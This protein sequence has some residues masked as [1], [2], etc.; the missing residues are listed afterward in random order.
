QLC[1]ELRHRDW[2]GQDFRNTYALLGEKDIGTVI[3]DTAGRRDVLHMRLTAPFVFIRWVGNGGHPKDFARLEDWGHRLKTW[4]DKGMR[5][6]YFIIH[7]PD[8]GYAPDLVLRAVETFNA[9]CGTSLKPPKLLSPE[10][11]P[12]TLF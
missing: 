9:I 6:I 2:F 8:E 11:P 7:N 3:T 1:L 5:E 4:M 10:P 12:L